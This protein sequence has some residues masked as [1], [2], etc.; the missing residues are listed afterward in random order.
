ME[1]CFENCLCC[2]DTPLVVIVTQ[3]Y[4]LKGSLLEPETPYYHSLNTFNTIYIQK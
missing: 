4:L 3:L 1:E 2:I